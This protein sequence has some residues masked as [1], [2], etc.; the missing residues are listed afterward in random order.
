MCSA[1]APGFHPRNRH[2]G[3]YDVAALVEASPE[4]G[5]FVLRTPGGALS[6]DFADPRAVKALNLA[7]LTAHY[8]VRGWDIPEGYLCPPI[9]GRAD[10]VHHLADLLAR[11]RGGAIPRG[12]AVRT[13]WSSGWPPRRPATNGAEGRSVRL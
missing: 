4:L 10:Y 3:R 6:I 13:S 12:A 7:L 5:P 1:E 2:Q 9:P 8:G 11:R